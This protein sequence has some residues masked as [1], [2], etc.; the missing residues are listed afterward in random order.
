M[1]KIKT[2][3]VYFVAN[4]RVIEMTFAFLNSF[5]KFNP[6][7]SLCM[8]PFRSDTDQ[9]IGLKEKYNYS[10]YNNDEV[11]SFCDDI[12]RQFHGE[13]IGHYRKLAIWQG[14]FDEFVYIDIDMLVLKNID[15][16]FLLL[17]QYDFITSN[18]NMSGSEK[19][20]WKESIYQTNALN[21]DQIKYAANTGFIVSKK[22]VITKDYIESRL[23]SALK[24]SN[25]MELHC[26][27]Q[28]LINFLIVTSDKRYTSLYALIDTPLYPQNYVEF[29][30]GSKKKYLL[31][32]MQTLSKS[33]WRDVFL[34]HW[35][36]VWQLRKVEINL[37]ILLSILKIKKTI[38]TTSLLM[39][40][41]R[42][43]KKYRYM[44]HA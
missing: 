12:S 34:I 3:G 13:I 15:F 23:S 20:V 18:S 9:L 26:S 21:H 11:L 1:S 6:E 44:K 16:V 8:I 17:D 7:I 4:D 30:A 36:G 40:L 24:L 31:K 25:H 32:N 10:I 19:W 28:P 2:R 42:L 43:W 5:R 22:N 14:D 37:Y 27:D 39:P 38:W 35:A 41:R 33:K 29:W